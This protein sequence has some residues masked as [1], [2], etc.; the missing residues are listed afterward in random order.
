MPHKL[1]NRALKR[2]RQPGKPLMVVGMHRSGTSFLTGSL[3]EAGLELGEHSAWN[4]HNLKG[5]REN[6]SIVALHDEILIRQGY[7]WDNPPEQTLYWSAAENQKAQRLIRQYR[8]IPHWGFKDPRALLFV[9]NWQA[10]LPDLQ[11][12]GIFRHPAAVARSLDARGGMSE[13]H[14]HRL[15]RIYNQ[16]LLRL[17]LRN[18]FPLL[19]FDQDETL[20]HQK[21]DS[22]LVHFGLKIPRG[23]RF[24]SADLKH[25]RAEESALPAGL[26]AL[27]RELLSLAI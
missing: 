3:Q 2:F 10:V 14:A 9:D 26:D 11:Y 7:A 6:Q 21:L 20:L 16:H 1:L 25:H 18:P 19:C 12:V 13:E 15:W 24:Y 5:N 4:P 8:G 27:Y 17:Y 22:T 23:K